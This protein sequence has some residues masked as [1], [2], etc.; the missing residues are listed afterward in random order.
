MHISEIQSK[1]DKIGFVLEI[2]A[3]EIV[4]KKSAYC[5]GNT[6]RRELTC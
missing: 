6:C 5:D 3:F 4:V 1:I 2:K